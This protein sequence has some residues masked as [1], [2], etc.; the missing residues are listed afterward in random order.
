MRIEIQE[1]RLGFETGAFP[2]PAEGTSDC[3]VLSASNYE[4]IAS[5]SSLQVQILFFR[6]RTGCAFAMKRF[7]L[8]GG[9]AG[10]GAAYYV[11][12]GKKVYNETVR[13][14]SKLALLRF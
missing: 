8:Y 9:I 2:R 7:G 13:N 4:V 10:L 14:F 6:I 11:F 5:T 1:S 12:R 3:D